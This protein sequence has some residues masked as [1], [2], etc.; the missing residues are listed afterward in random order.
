MSRKTG[1]I[2]SQC[3]CSMSLSSRVCL[4]VGVDSIG[5]EVYYQRLFGKMGVKLPVNAT[6]MLRNMKK[7]E[8]TTTVSTRPFRFGKGKEAHCSLLR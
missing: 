7:K 1:N 3:R 6:I 2:V 8:T 4:A 5:Q